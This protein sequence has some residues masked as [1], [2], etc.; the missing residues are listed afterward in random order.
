VATWILWK[1]DRPDTGE[2][3]ESDKLNFSWSAADIFEFLEW[4]K[5]KLDR[6]A[7]RLDEVGK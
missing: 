7:F 1:F 6:V 2:I 5:A 4:F 3:L